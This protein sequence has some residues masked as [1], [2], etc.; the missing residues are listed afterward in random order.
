MVL[1]RAAVFLDRDGVI[2]ENR[3][4]YVRSWS[5][6]AFIPGA[7]DALVRLNATPYLVVL[8]TNQSAVGRGVIS[9]EKAF[10]IQCEIEKSIRA[11]G[12]RVDDTLMCPH[13][14]WEDCP[15]RKP[16]PGLIL[17][18]AEKH[19]L[20]LKRSFM[21]GDA[22]SDVQ[23]GRSAGVGQSALV[24]TGRGKD[25]I[26]LAEANSLAPIEVYPR[27]SDFIDHLLSDSV[28]T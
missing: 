28:G 9:A 14:P 16:Q 25:Q 13:A 20:D 21:I 19:A 1:M 7:L 11:A 23:A 17:L 12:G 8:V 10:E 26:H 2:I 6:V 27:L 18:A 5:D 4:E 15:C 3:A 22:L 24:L